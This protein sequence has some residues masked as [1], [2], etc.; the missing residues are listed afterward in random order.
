MAFTK[1]RWVGSWLLLTI[2]VSIGRGSPS[3]R[4]QFR[5]HLQ[6]SPTTWSWM[7]D[8]DV[9]WDS[10]VR[11][12][13]LDAVFGWRASVRDPLFLLSLI[14]LLGSRLP[15]KDYSCWINYR[16]LGRDISGTWLQSNDERLET[17]IGNE[18]RWIPWLCTWEPY[19]EL[20]IGITIAERFWELVSFME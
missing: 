3:T 7:N 18:N 20:L 11:L 2:I 5:N 6:S 13:P 16:K 1:F 17:Q 10:F 19:V 4:H 14:G 12:F 9:P 15:C 8:I